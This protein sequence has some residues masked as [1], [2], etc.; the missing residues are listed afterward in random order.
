VFG[1]RV[2]WAGLPINAKAPNTNE[3]YICNQ[4]DQRSPD[5][6]DKCDEFDK[7]KEHCED[8]DDDIELGDAIMLISH[9]W[10]LITGR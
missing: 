10:K 2:I 1:I 7:K 4:G 9:R 8:R 6:H 3:Y 5:V